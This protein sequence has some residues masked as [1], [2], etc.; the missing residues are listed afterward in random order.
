M[1]TEGYLPIREYAVIGDGRTAALV[2]LDGSIDW[3]A[4][5]NIDSAST[6]GRILDANRGGAFTLQPAVPF[7]SERRYLPDSNVLE[8]TF[9]TDRGVVRVV[10]ALTLPD[11][12]LAPMRELVRSIEGVAGSVPIGWRFA[13]RAEYGLLTPRFERRGDVPV[14]TWGSHAIAACHWNAGTPTPNDGAVTGAV[15]VSAGDRA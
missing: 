8:T 11:G 7:Q 4:F 13:P 6:F 5:P 12:D 14:A 2:G 3:L 1:R 10:D 15:E 9:R